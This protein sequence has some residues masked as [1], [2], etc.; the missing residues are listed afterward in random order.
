MESIDKIKIRH[1]YYPASVS[2]DRIYCTFENRRKLKK[3]A[4]DLIGRQLVRPQKSGKLKIAP[5]KWNSIERKFGQV[6]TR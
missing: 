4:S 5:G 1:G 2:S 6:Y 3:V